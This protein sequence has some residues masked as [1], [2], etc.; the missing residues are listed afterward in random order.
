L[1]VTSVTILNATPTQ[2]SCQIDPATPHDA[3]DLVLTYGGSTDPDG[4]LVT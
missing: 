3:D 1:A 4:D 2:P